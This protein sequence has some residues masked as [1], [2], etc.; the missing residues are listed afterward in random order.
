MY[1]EPVILRDIQGLTYEEISEIL[2]IEVGTVKS[3]I[4]RGRK[5]LQKLL[6]NVYGD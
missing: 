6:K 3:R 1:R 5:R 2:N 4:N